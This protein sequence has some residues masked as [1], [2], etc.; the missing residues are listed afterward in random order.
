MLRLYKTF[1]YKFLTFYRILLLLLFNI[2][3]MQSATQLI[4]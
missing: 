4:I 3:N 1:K 2:N